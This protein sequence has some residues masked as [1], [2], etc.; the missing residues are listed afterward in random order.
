MAALLNLK[1]VSECFRDAPLNPY[2]RVAWA[3]RYSKAYLGRSD[4]ASARA[5]APASAGCASAEETF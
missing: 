5:V 4:G 2:V 3:A 1:Y